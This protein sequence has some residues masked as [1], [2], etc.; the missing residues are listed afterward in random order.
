MMNRGH[1]ICVCVNDTATP[2]WSLRLAEEGWSVITL[3]PEQLDSERIE[4]ETAAMVVVNNAKGWLDSDF[5]TE[6]HARHGLSWLLLFDAWNQDYLAR[7]LALGHSHWLV[8]DMAG[9]WLDMLPGMVARLVGTSHRSL[10]RHVRLLLNSLDEGVVGLRPR[11]EIAWINSAA[12]RIIGMSADDVLE[13]RQED[14]LQLYEQPRQENSDM[15]ESLAWSVSRDGFDILSLDCWCQS[16]GDNR[17]PVSFSLTPISG[18]P[19][20]AGVAILQDISERKDMER[21]LRKVRKEAQTATRAKTEFL[22]T[23]SH[24]IRTPM[25]A[26][27]GMSELLG[28][29]RLTAE[30]ERYI[31]IFRHSGEVLLDLINDIL[32][33]SNVEA[34]LLEVD[35][36]PFDLIELVD[37]IA[38]I[39]GLRA[40]DKELYM[41]T[42][43]S[44]SVPCDVVGDPARLRQI[45]VNLVGNA[46][47]FT[48][49]GE[50]GIRISWESTDERMGLFR[51]AVSDTGIG[52][53]QEKQK[54]IFQP[55]TQADSSVTRTHGGTGL[56]LTICHRLVDLMGGSIHVKSRPGRGSTFWF[57][58]PLEYRHQSK[59][60][61]HRGLPDFTGCR[62][63]LHSDSYAS[64]LALREMLGVVNME[65]KTVGNHDALVR[66]I[67]VAWARGA[68]Y[69]VIGLDSQTPFPGM[70]KFIYASRLRGRQQCGTTP[71]LIFSLPGPRRDPEK[72]SRL[73]VTQI[74]KPI[75]RNELIA[76]VAQLLNIVWDQHDAESDQHD[77]RYLTDSARPMKILL[78]E[79]SVDNALLIRAYLEKTPHKVDVAENG[80]LAT[81]MFIQNEYD[82][83]LMDVQMPILDGYSATREIRAWEVENNQPPT[84]ILA[85]TANVLQEHRRRSIA[86]GCDGHLTKPIKKRELMR[87]I[88]RF[89]KEDTLEDVEQIPIPLPE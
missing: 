30:Q 71:I 44:P 68:P 38:D 32:D 79:D 88:H 26:I 33:L 19:G 72:L 18:D 65:V 7:A 20:L 16:G 53:S 61:E 67:E 49:R 83:V 3:T 60:V 70:D 4:V 63:L 52:I 14:V 89:S 47:K 74:I 77:E 17:V 21:V 86:S 36:T 11:G 80:R 13:N 64:K 10:R 43:F 66:E 40:L 25:N 29:T 6:S 55:F 12:L 34:G 59:Q 87:E 37:S 56:G 81:E 22:A 75:R 27:I 5:A 31:N 51:F 15:P 73:G 50:V 2:D 82:L 62:M 8:R 42:H 41:L 35:H 76:T 39:M 46:I 57:E 78:A 45:L 84:K 24:E 1:L 48:E 9:Q 58:V 54:S 28:Q 69:H 85:L 23:M